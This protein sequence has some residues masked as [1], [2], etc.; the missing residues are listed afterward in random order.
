MRK[1]KL[2][3]KQISNPSSGEI[4]DNICHNTGKNF[5]S[6]DWHPFCPVTALFIKKA[7]FDFNNKGCYF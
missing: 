3:I 7:Y 4:I 5:P 2:K 1:N 6:F